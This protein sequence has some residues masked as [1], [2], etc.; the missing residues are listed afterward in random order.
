MFSLHETT[1]IR[2]LRV[3]FFALCVLPCCAVLGWT[4]FLRTPA[5]RHLHER[6]I[7]AATGCR[8]VLARASTP[9]PRGHRTV[10]TLAAMAVAVVCGY[11]AM[12]A[13]GGLWIIGTAEYLPVQVFVVTAV[14]VLA[15]IAAVWL[16]LAVGRL[17]PSPATAPA[18]SR[19]SPCGRGT[20]P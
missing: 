20:P 9:R 16:G 5:Y 8:A 19:P 15:L 2:V 1:R 12:G 6:A 10:P 14:G 13:A 18:L 11:L 3:A 17:L 4:V 7:A